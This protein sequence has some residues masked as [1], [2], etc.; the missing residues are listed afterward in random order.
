MNYVINS[1]TEQI[2]LNG[3]ISLNTKSKIDSDDFS[4]YEE[5]K[6]NYFA[7]RIYYNELKYTLISQEPKTEMFNF[8]S[9][10]GGILGLFLS[11]SFLSFI[12]IFE[13][14]F[15]IMFISFKK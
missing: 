12:E 13:F 15:E 9:N 5:L 3:N 2:A 7:L 8:I 6:K 11:I 1:Y 14:I 10:I 4:T